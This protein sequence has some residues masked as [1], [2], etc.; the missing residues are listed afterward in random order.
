RLGTVRQPGSGVSEQLV[1]VMPGEI[2][3]D[4]QAGDEEQTQGRSQEVRSPGAFIHGAFPFGDA[5][6]TGRYV[7]PSWSK[8]KAKTSTCSATV[9]DR[10][11]PIPCPLVALVRSS[12]GRP[13]DVAVCSRAV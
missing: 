12:T 6:P 10:A 13:E 9:S 8:R 1:L 11:L 3:S 5:R 7:T 2:G 4:S